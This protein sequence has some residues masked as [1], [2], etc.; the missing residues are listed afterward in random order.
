MKASCVEARNILKNLHFPLTKQNVIQQ[1]MKHG[2]DSN[3]IG[4][5]QKIPDREYT[6]YE[7]VIK[8]CES[9]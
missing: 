8:E 6:S 3:V 7:S 9:T 2:A 1:A 4:D 5:L